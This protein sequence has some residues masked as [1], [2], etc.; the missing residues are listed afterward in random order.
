MHRSVPLSEVRPESVAVLSDVGAASWALRQCSRRQ[1]AVS[2]RIGGY[3][4]GAESD[5]DLLGIGL[6]A[7]AAADISNRLPYLGGVIGVAILGHSLDLI[8]DRAHILGEHRAILAV[9]GAA[10]FIGLPA[11]SRCQAAGRNLSRRT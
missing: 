5:I 6:P 10:L 4:A 9:F 11:Q 8:G 1:R 3:G 2:V 7:A